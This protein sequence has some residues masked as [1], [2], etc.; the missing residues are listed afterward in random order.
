MRE[1]GY[2]SYLP[3]RMPSVSNHLQIFGFRLRRTSVLEIGQRLKE[4]LLPL[5]LLVITN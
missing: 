3:I 4:Y 2:F 1:T 5:C